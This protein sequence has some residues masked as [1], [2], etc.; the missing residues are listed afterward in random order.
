MGGLM[1]QVCMYAHVH[2]HTHTQTQFFGGVRGHAGHGGEYS[3]PSRQS[4]SF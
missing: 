3:M 4:N 2:T 1:E